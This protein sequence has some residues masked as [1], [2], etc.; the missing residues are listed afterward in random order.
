MGELIG[1]VT[2]L[3]GFFLINNTLAGGLASGKLAKLAYLSWY[4]FFGY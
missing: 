4:G 3:F 2:S 1:T